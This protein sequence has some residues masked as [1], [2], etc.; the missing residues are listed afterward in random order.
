[1]SPAVRFLAVVVVAVAM[2]PAS[3]GAAPVLG[4]NVN[5]VLNDGLPSDVQARQ[6]ALVGR[7]GITDVRS[8]AFWGLDQATRPLLGLTLVWTGSDDRI[9]ALDRAGL[10]WDPVMD[11]SPEWQQ[12]EHGQGHSGPRDVGA[13]ADWTRQW[14]ARYG[15]RGT[16]W[17]THPDLPRRN[18]RRYEIWNEENGVFWLPHPDP[19]RYADLYLAARQ[20]IHSSDPAAQVS[21]GGLADGDADEFLSAMVQARPALR[22]AVD[23]VA[24]H[25]YGRTAKATVDVVASLRRTMRTVG[26]GARPLVL[27]EYGWKLS[28]RA[29]DGFVL[30]D[31]TRAGDL[32]LTSDALARSDC[33]VSGIYPY[34]WLTPERTLFHGEDWWGLVTPG[35]TIRPPGRAYLDAVA[36]LRALPASSRSLP[37]CGSGGSAA[38]LQLGLTARRSGPRCSA[39]SLSYAGW[40]LNGLRVSVRGG[41]PVRTDLNGLARACGRSGQVRLGYWA[42]SPVVRLS[43]PRRRRRHVR[44]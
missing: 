40:P 25:P 39:L 24:L 31:P 12:S 27:N 44:T 42:V 3:A 13:F 11:Y 21:I 22:Q 35:G 18:V 30:P 15:S 20:A 17:V 2:L 1:M 38:P 41:R 5:R 10:R 28:G 33:N 32:A 36:R 29:G 14:A 6:L 4:I 8:D 43:H 7:S 23:A 16:F 37:I 26:L 34:T 9:T 19:A